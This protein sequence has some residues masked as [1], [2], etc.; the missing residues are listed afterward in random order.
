LITI[1]AALLAVF[2]VSGSLSSLSIRSLTSRSERNTDALAAAVKLGSLSMQLSSAADMIV[3]AAYKHDDA[4]IESEWAD[5]QKGLSALEQQASTLAARTD[6]PENRT[7]AGD[8]VDAMHKWHALVEQAVRA[9]HQRDTAAADKAMEESE[10]FSDDKASVLLDQIVEGEL[11]HTRETN[12]AA[13][14]RDRL[15]TI[16]LIVVLIGIAAVIAVVVRG[17][18]GQLRNV[19]SELKGGASAVLAASA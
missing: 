15:N 18:D 16:G 2:V 4:G 6:V 3:V 14:S 7:R 19:A 10:A 11:A 8:V 12:T 17:M 13:R 5:A 9:A 1:L